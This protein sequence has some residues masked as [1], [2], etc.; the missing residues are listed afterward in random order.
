MLIGYLR[1]DSSNLEEAVVLAV[2]TEGLFALLSL[3]LQYS[4]FICLFVSS[5]DAC[6]YFC[7]GN[8]WRTDLNVI[9][10]DDHEWFEN[11]L[12]FA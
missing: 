5:F 9:A 10:V 7:A 12:F 1:S 8:L 11:D 2:A 4:H 3:K 6:N